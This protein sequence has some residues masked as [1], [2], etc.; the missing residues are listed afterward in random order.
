[1]AISAG[2]A[3][4]SPAV[5]RF[6]EEVRQS[7]AAAVRRIVESSGFFYAS[8]VDVA[9]ELVRE[10]LARG[11]QSGYHFLFCDSG[12][13]AIGYACFGPIACTAWSWDLYWIAVSQDRRGGGVGRRLLEAAEQRIAAAGGRRVYIETSSRDLYIPTR[14][15]YLRCGYRVEAIID[16]FYG[17]GDSKYLFSKAL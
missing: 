16:E 14:E 11:L 5:L 8:E 13:E 15:F 17:P 1:M 2:T 3:E 6:R 12:E 4:V 10:R 7:D 9:E